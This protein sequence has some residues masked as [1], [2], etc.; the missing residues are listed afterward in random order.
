MFWMFHLAIAENLSLFDAFPG[1]IP[2]VIH[3]IQTGYYGREGYGS[4]GFRRYRCG[5]KPWSSQ[6][7]PALL[8][9][10]RNY[11]RVERNKSTEAGLL[12][13]YGIVLKF[14]GLDSRNFAGGFA[15][16]RNKGQ[17]VTVKS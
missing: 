8:R 6:D 11:F 13:R 14:L 9:F 12:L 5:L 17:A 7:R 15:E 10:Q 2:A 1:S 16:Q 3:S 4:R